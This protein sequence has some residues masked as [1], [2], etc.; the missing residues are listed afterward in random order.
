MSPPLRLH[1]LQVGFTPS[2]PPRFGP[3]PSTHRGCPWL[4][5]ALSP[6]WAVRVPAGF[7]VRSRRSTRRTTPSHGTILLA[8]TPRTITPRTHQPTVDERTATGLGP[9]LRFPGTALPTG[10]TTRF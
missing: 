1:Q 5:L 7:T 9:T 2:I 4:P 10:G 3:F 6:G 8:I